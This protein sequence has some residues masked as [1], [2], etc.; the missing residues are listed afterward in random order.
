MI[1]EQAMVKEVKA[2]EGSRKAAEMR[3][4]EQVAIEAEADRDRAEKKSAATKMLAEAATAEHAA[5]GLADANVQTAKAAASEKQGMAEA[6]V[7][8]EKYMSEAQGIT[9]KATAMK[10]L[11]GVGKE[12]EEFKLRLEKDKAIEIAA[13][14]AQKSI[15]GEQAA[16]C[17]GLRSVQPRSISSVATDV[18]QSNLRRGQRRKS[19]RSLRQ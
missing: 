4:S 2:A 9:E 12:H 15:A 1:A 6:R 7:L 5:E 13:I 19:H 10:E 3:G 8:K 16:L 18:L 14:D 17:S 11:D